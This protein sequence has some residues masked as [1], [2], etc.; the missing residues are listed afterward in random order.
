MEHCPYCRP[1][2]A[3]RIRLAHAVAASLRAW[4]AVSH[5]G[6]QVGAIVQLHGA[7]TR[8]SSTI[9]IRIS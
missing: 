9:L 6:Q 8:T 7:A 5:V 4:S 2:E 1:V 3:H